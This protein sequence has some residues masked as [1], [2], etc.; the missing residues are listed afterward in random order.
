MNR[1]FRRHSQLI[2]LFA[3]AIVL[4]AALAPSLSRALA[5]DAASP[6]SLMCASGAWTITEFPQQPGSGSSEPAGV[7]HASDHCPLCR[8]ASSDAVAL[9]PAVSIPA[10]RAF[11]APRVAVPEFAIAFQSRFESPPARGPPIS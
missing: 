7:P 4:F 5:P 8:H 1:F 11:A 6:W 3:G 2:S 9:A 10:P